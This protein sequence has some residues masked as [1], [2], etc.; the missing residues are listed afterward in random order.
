[1][2][3]PL[4]LPLTVTLT[5]VID[6]SGAVTMTVWVELA[7]KSI[8]EMVE[9]EPTVP[10]VAVIIG[11]PAGASV[12][13]EPVSSSELPMVLCAAMAKVCHVDDVRPVAV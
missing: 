6:E 3:V 4:P 8:S 5:F 12:E 2:P 1:V 9:G 11:E 10:D 7:G 13:R